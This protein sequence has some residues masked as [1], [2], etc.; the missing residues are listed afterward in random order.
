MNDREDL[1][2][3]INW[4]DNNDTV[5]IK[6]W[7]N[8]YFVISTMG[9]LLGITKDDSK[10]SLYDTNFTDFT[11]GGEDECEKRPETFCFKP[12]SRKWTIVPLCY[13]FDMPCSNSGTIL[14]LNRN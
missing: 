3:N 11:K 8:E 9:P 13:L 5:K 12:K 10:K 1:T 6:F 4:C 2:I 14:A 7:K